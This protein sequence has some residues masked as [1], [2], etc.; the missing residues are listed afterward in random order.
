MAEV[1]VYVKTN[2]KK[3]TFASSGNRSTDHLMAELLWLQTRNFSRQKTHCRQWDCRNTC[4]K[5]VD[6]IC[7]CEFTL[8]HYFDFAIRQLIP[9]TE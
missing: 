4:S 2:P 6:Q 1:I 8:V 3:M 9:L 5:P 7:I